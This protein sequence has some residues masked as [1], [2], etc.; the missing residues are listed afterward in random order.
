[1]HS[2]RKG[3]QDPDLTSSEIEIE[4]DLSK[5]LAAAIQVSITEEED[6]FQLVITACLSV[7]ILG[8]ET[9][10]DAAMGQMTRMAWASVESVRPQPFHFTC[11]GLGDGAWRVGYQMRTSV[12]SS[13]YLHKAAPPEQVV[14]QLKLVCL[15]G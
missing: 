7:L 15:L 13:C 3:T 12:A 8:C 5:G 6:E 1:L 14:D 4:I 10:L 9:K 2:N 11:R